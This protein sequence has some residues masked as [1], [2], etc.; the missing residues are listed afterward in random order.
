MILYRRRPRPDDFSERMGEGNDGSFMMEQVSSLPVLEMT[1]DEQ[2]TKVVETSI[3]LLDQHI[4]L[5]KEYSP[6]WLPGAGGILA[7][8]LKFY[9]PLFKSKYSNS[10]S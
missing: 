1:D 5:V 9:D 7:V 10:G 2:N 4:A 3:P 6:W 8:G